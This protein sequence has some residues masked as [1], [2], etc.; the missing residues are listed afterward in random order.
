MPLDLLRVSAQIRDMGE[1]LVARR[2]DQ[3]QRLALAR[4]M[5]RELDW[6]VLAEQAD[7]VAER[8]AV[9]TEPVWVTA[10]APPRPASYTALA[11]DGSEIDPDRHGGGGDFYVINLGR[12]RIPYG[13][14]R[15]DVELRSTTHLGYTDEE[16]FIVD[17]SDPRR[18][19]PMRDRHLDA[20][21]TVEEMRALADLAEGEAGRNVGAGGRAG[22]RDAAVLGARGATAR[23]PAGALLRRL[24]RAAR[25]PAPGRCY[26][27][28]VRQPLAWRGPG[29]PAARGMRRAAGN[30]RSLPRS[31]AGVRAAR[32]DRRVPRPAAG[33]RALGPVPRAL[34]RARPVLRAASRLFLPAQR[35]R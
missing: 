13:Q 20:L 11:T 15:R 14:P 30:V 27:R 4:E 32:A 34:E 26:A 16:L 23:L 5:L 18:Q 6:R 25:P 22:R 19:V 28:R 2:S 3:G 10:A 12:V 8:V 21:R 24:R 35:R 31:A 29:Q 17:A 9:P 1:F 7:Q 33:R